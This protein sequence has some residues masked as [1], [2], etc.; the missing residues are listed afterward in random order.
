[1]GGLR[2]A[3]RRTV[4]LEI[5]AGKV[6]AVNPIKL[7]ALHVVRRPLVAMP[8][9]WLATMVAPTA[10]ADMINGK[11]VL[12]K[13]ET[14]AAAPSHLFG[15]MHSDDARVLD[16]PDAADEAFAAAD[17][18]ALEVLIAEPQ[19]A[20]ELGLKLAPELIMTDGRTL[21]QLIGADRLETVAEALARTGMPAVAARLL[22]P[23]VAY[24]LLNVPAPRRGPDGEELPKLDIQLERDARAQGKQLAALE[25]IDEQIALFRGS[26]E[27]KEILLLRELIDSAQQR[28]GAAA[29]MDALFAMVVDLYEDGEIGMILEVTQPPMPPEET[30]ATEMILDRLLFQRNIIM[31]ERMKSLL[32]R[33]NAFIAI[34]AAHLPGEQ[35]VLNLLAEQGYRITRVH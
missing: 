16:L 21:D 35:G 6:K 1:M 17:T 22:K 24:L 10:A 15:T 28:G 30:A 25:T 19:A 8:I 31:V 29:Y 27:E 34:G 33:G 2:S 5:A 12:W 3:R 20:T 14:E 26:D 4:D 23:W 18:V 32:A 13:I 9:L 7:M 11:G